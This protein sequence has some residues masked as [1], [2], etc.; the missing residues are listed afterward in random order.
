MRATYPPSNNPNHS[1]VV[2]YV[3]HSISLGDFLF[4]LGMKMVRNDAKFQDRR[5]EAGRESRETIA[6]DS[7]GT[8]S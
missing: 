5:P 4:L 6:A 1:S 3:L 8:A 7:V 2:F